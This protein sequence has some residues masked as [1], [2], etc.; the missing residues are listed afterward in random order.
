MEDV[1]EGAGIG[2]LNSAGSENVG[3]VGAGVDVLDGTGVRI[4]GGAGVD[5]LDG[6]GAGILDGTGVD[7]LDGTGVNVLDGPGVIVCSGAT[8]GTA[9]AA[10]GAVGSDVA[11]CSVVGSVGAMAEGIISGVGFDEGKRASVC[12]IVWGGKLEVGSGVVVGE[13]KTGCTMSSMSSI[14]TFG[15]FSNTSNSPIATPLS[16]RARDLHSSGAMWFNEYAKHV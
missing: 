9:N 8:G 3:V 10:C 2:V 13:G 14:T 6:T 7:V 15:S 1:P 11:L 5:V 12:A 16:D 4:L